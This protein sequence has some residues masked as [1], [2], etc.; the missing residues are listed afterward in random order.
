MVFDRVEEKMLKWRMVVR[1]R[2]FWKDWGNWN[3]VIDGVLLL[4][5]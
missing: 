2:S 1:M 4:L 5:V 3:G